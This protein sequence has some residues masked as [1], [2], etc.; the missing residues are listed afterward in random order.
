L[1][2]SRDIS[3]PQVAINAFHQTRAGTRATWK[4][5]ALWF[6]LPR[7][8]E[9]EGAVHHQ[10]SPPTPW[11]AAYVY[12]TVPAGYKLFSVGTDGKESTGE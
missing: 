7:R 12:R 9:L 8:R 3:T 6:I 10:H 2:A 4:D 1:A 11:G 5:S